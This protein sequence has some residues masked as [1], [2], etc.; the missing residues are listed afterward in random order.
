MLVHLNP[1]K[2]KTTNI[3]IKSMT[4]S[5]HKSA[6]LSTSILVVHRCHKK[7]KLKMLV[8]LNPYKTKTTEIQMKSM[9]DSRYTSWK[10]KCQ[11]L[12]ATEYRFIIILSPAPDSFPPFWDQTAPLATEPDEVSESFKEKHIHGARIMSNKCSLQ[13]GTQSMQQ[14][15]RH[16]GEEKTGVGNARVIGGKRSH[17]LL[18]PI[19][20][21]NWS[22]K[23]SEKKEE[24]KKTRKKHKETHQKKN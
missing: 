1:Y 7:V 24:K 19:E 23:L 8:Q 13:Y 11:P 16:C 21:N 18:Q 17:R 4:D 10:G 14:Q 20:N 12:E 22:T 15:L 9:T 2:T 5:R 3:Q 6:S